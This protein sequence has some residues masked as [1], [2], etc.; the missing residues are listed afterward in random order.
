LQRLFLPGLIKEIAAGSLL[1]FAHKTPK[2][3]LKGVFLPLQ[4]AA[5]SLLHLWIFCIF[6]QKI[7]INGHALG[8][9]KV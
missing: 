8:V 1:R 7:P 4:Q 5:S 6:M 3:R 9:C 2:N